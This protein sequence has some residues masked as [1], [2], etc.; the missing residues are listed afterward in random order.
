MSRKTARSWHNALDERGWASAFQH[1]DVSVALAGESFEVAVGTSNGVVG[2]VLPDLVLPINKEIAMTESDQELDRYLESRPPECRL[3][4]LLEQWREHPNFAIGMRVAELSTIWL[5]HGWQKEA[6]SMFTWWLSQLGPDVIGNLNHTKRW[7]T[8]FQSS[9]V[10]ACQ[11]G[12]ASSLH[13]V[14][15][16]TG[17]PSFLSRIIDVVSINGQSL[18]P[19]IHIYTTC[20]GKLAWP[21]LDCPCLENIQ[22][23]QDK[24]VAVGTVPKRWFGFHSAEQM[25]KVVHK[26]EKSFRIAQEDRAFRLLVTVADQAIQ[27]EGSIRFT[28]KERS[29]DGLAHDPLGE[30]VC[31][32]HVTDGVGT[33]NDKQYEEIGVFDRLL[34][35]IRHHFGWGTGNLIFRGVAAKFSKFVLHFHELE[36]TCLQAVAKAEANGQPLAAAKMRKKASE[37]R[38]EAAAITRA[39]WDTWKRPLAPRA[40]GTRKAVYQNKARASFFDT[41][42]LA[43]WGLQAQMQQSLESARVAALARATRSQRRPART[44]KR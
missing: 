38:A 39:G 41:I 5:A 30:G 40:D 9:L 3:R 6:F 34:R 15:P 17:M 33:N 10:Q 31:K 35:L 29:G 18:L 13:A 24:G 7:L 43:Y 37:F 8:G 11:V 12:T 14:V 26:V 27:G 42:G 28:Q 4:G 20:A 44:H 21:L 36:Q 2:D 1:G 22:T 32:F 23:S 25:I 16:A 19:V